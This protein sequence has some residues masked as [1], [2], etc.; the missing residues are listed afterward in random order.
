MTD[1]QPIIDGLAECQ[2]VL[3]QTNEKR[4]SL[5]ARL[6]PCLDFYFPIGTVLNA[7]DDRLQTQQCTVMSQTVVY[8][9]KL[10]DWRIGTTYIYEHRGGK[11]TAVETVILYPYLSRYHPE[12]VTG[13]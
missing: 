13:E 11:V 10:G 5:K 12:E 7:T 4:H 6:L 2:Y 9:K 1:K 8:D 3:N